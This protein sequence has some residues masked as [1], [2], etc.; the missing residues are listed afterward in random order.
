MR[1]V[2]CGT[3]YPK[4]DIPNNCIRCGAPLTTKDEYNTMEKETSSS[5][6]PD[7]GNPSMIPRDGCEVCTICGYNYCDF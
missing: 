4:H 7:C 3:L 6:C 2:G 1:C 5:T